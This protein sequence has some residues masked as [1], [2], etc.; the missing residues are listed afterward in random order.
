MLWEILRCRIR[1]IPL[2]SCPWAIQTRPLFL[3]QRLQPCHS[4]ACHWNWNRFKHWFQSFRIKA[5][6]YALYELDR[7]TVSEFGAQSWSSC[8]W[9]QFGWPPQIEFS[10]FR[11]VEKDWRSIAK[12]ICKNQET[13][14]RLVKFIEGACRKPSEWLD[15]S[16][17]P[18]HWLP[19]QRH[20]HLNDLNIH[21]AVQHHAVVHVL[22]DRLRSSSSNKPPDSCLKGRQQKY[23][24]DLICKILQRLGWPRYLW[25]AYT[26]NWSRIL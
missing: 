26:L 21:N 5:S 10:E 12:S 9:S 4:P 2:E 15:Q 7:G 25:I 11:N 8:N 3:L 6:L 14:P 16:P 18:K 24:S 23:V 19:E 13:R 22:T 17:H 1:H 20:I